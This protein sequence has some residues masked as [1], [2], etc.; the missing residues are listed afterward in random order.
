MAMVDPLTRAFNRNEFE[1]RFR[2]MTQANRRSTT[3]MCLILFDIDHLKT[4]NDTLGHLMGDRVIK[5]IAQLASRTIRGQD[6]LVRWGGDEFILLIQN[7]IE[8]TRQVA[9][10]LRKAVASHKY[11]DTP[12]SSDV[13]NR[14]SI[15]CGITAYQSGQTLDTVLLRA[16]KALYQAKA[17]GRNRVV[18]TEDSP[19]V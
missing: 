1:L 3:P 16:D 4:I 5:D 13:T 19:K 7:D 8:T 6:L 12:D 17:K 15:S 18:T 9:E 10:R 11:N 14:I 2:H